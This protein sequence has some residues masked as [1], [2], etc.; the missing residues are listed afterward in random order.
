MSSFAKAMASKKPA[1]PGIWGR[2]RPISSFCPSPTA[3]SAPSAAAWRAAREGMPSLRLANIASLIHPLS[4]DTYCEN[5]LS[6]ARAILIRI[7]GGVDYWPYGIEQIQKL[8]AR[9]KYRT[10]R[11]PG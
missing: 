3:I 6:G 11:D 4:V 10:R 1:R 2:A 8:A 5:T 7:L 9:E